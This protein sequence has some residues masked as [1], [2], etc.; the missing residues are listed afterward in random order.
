VGGAIRDE[1][2]ERNSDQLDEQILAEQSGGRAFMNTNDLSGVIDKVTSESGHFYTLSYV[3]DNVKMDGRFRNIGITVAGG[4][5]NLSYRRGYFA[6]DTG[7]PGFPINAGSKKIE[8]VSQLS[9]LE[10]DTLRPFMDLGMPQSDQIVYKIRMI[11]TPTAEDAHKKNDKN[12]YR[13][14]F[15]IELRDLDLDLGADGVR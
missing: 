14:D 13:V 15:A 1:D 6:V 11:P 12:Q 5:Y 8:T 10:D 4:K 9:L 3:P 2:K 7:L